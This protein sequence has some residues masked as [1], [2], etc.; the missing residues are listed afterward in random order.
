MKLQY[1]RTAEDESTSSPS[2]DADPPSAAPVNEASTTPRPAILETHASELRTIELLAWGRHGGTCYP[3]RTCQCRSV[4]PYAEI[5]SINVDPQ[6]SGMQKSLYTLPPHLTLPTEQA[7]EMMR[8]HFEYILWHHNVFH[9][10]TFLEQCEDFW[11]HGTVTHPLW[12]ALYL[13]VSAVG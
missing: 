9:A 1:G 6:W 7:R 5:T 13:S 2:D 8:F 11:T 12:M 10:P 4:R 3:H